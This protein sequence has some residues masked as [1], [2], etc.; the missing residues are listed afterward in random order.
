MFPIVDRRY[1][2]TLLAL[3]G[4]GSDQRSIGLPPYKYAYLRYIIRIPSTGTYTVPY[5]FVVSSARAHLIPPR[6]VPFS[7]F[8]NPRRACAGGLL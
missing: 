6:V 2:S 4:S 7:A 5:R 3:Y 8:I 1:G